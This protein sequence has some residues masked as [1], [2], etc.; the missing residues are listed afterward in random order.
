MKAVRANPLFPI[1]MMV[2][3]APW[4]AATHWRRA[5]FQ[6]KMKKPAE[7]SEGGQTEP[8]AAPKSNANQVSVKTVYAFHPVSMEPHAQREPIATSM[9]IACLSTPWAI[10]VMRT[11]NVQVA[12]V[13]AVFSILKPVSA[14]ITM[15][16]SKENIVGLS[17]SMSVFR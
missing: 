13:K 3:P 4:T 11:L 7:V 12:R 15:T 14:W 17:E 1:V 8:L 9:A 2:T 10:P 6:W 16:V 5:V